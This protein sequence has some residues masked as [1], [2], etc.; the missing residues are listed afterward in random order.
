MD[1]HRKDSNNTLEAALNVVR[2]SEPDRL[3][4]ETGTARVWAH[5]GYEGSSFERGGYLQ[6]GFDDIDWL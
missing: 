6:R 1:G 4:M 2:N 3:E 5:I